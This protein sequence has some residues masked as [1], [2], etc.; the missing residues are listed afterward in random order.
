M[1]PI[2][3]LHVVTYMGRGGLESMLM[4]YYRNINRERIQFD[5]E[6]DYDKEILEMG[7]KIYHISRLIPWSSSYK[8]I[9]KNFFRKHMEYRIIH[10]HQD[11][12][13]SVAL[14]C[15]EECGIPVRIAHSHTSNL[16]RNFKYYIKRYY[17]KKIPDYATD[18]FACGKAAGDWMFGGKS[19]SIIKNAIDTSAFRYNPETADLVRKELGIGDNYVVGH[20][21]RFVP[22]KNH[23]FITDVFNVIA[24]LREDARLL[25]VGDGECR[26]EISEKVKMLGLEEKV[27]FTGVRSDVNE[28]MQA[29]DAFIF[30]S[31]YEGL[32]LVAIEAQASGLPCLVSDRVPN[33]CIVTDGLVVQMSLDKSPTEWAETLLGLPSQRREVFST[34]VIESGYDI[35][36]AA[37]ELEH[38]YFQKLGQIDS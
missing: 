3:I 13:S 8:K 19:F 29:M 26:N 11:C 36:T 35:K 16:D 20:V 17:M 2:R 33:D 1:E 28:L 37:K 9:L 4:N 7:G 14:E 25:L 21:G 34:Q 15:A 12:L 23:E 31:L 22:L 18:L 38:F 5:F 24:S 32:G 10:V 6:A 27:I 30:P